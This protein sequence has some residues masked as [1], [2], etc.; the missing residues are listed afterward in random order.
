MLLSPLTRAAQCRRRR[1]ATRPLG[2]WGCHP[3]S[4]D[5]RHRRISAATTYQFIAVSNSTGWPPRRERGRRPPAPAAPA[6]AASRRPLPPPAPR[7]PLARRRWRPLPTAPAPWWRPRPP[8]R[9]PP[10]TSPTARP[11]R[12][13]P[14]PR[15]RRGGTA[16]A[17]PRGTRSPP[18]TCRPTLSAGCRADRR[19]AGGGK[20]RRRLSVHRWRRRVG[21][22]QLPVGGKHSR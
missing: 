9:R 8:S 6:R 20:A 4:R 16:A 14:T 17:A 11:P 10:Q 5:G 12:R 3:T 13:T 2:Q 18:P 15:R 19:D 21:R 1:R 22:Q 7:P